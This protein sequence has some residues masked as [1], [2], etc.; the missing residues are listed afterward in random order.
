VT[1]YTKEGLTAQCANNIGRLE[2]LIDEVNGMLGNTGAI[3]GCVVD[4]IGTLCINRDTMSLK[5][6][7]NM[8]IKKTSVL[9][10]ILQ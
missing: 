2:P 8:L 7:C 6:V 4:I 3:A 10:I 9:D 1:R 5:S